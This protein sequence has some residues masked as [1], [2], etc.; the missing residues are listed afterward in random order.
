MCPHALFF[1]GVI[2]NICSYSNYH[3]HTS[4]QR[5]HPGYI[6]YV[7][8][9][10]GLHLS[11]NYIDVK[12]S[13]TLTSFLG[14][15]NFTRILV[16]HLVGC[17]DTSMPLSQE[18]CVLLLIEDLPTSVSTLSSQSDIQA[19]FEQLIYLYVCKQCCIL[20]APQH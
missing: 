20:L 14:S 15:C 8:K 2:K 4:D 1:A 18:E 19:T 11:S 10:P 12:C 17:S 7:A 13:A 9:L 6:S 3:F 16:S 5:S